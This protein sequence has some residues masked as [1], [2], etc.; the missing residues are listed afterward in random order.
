M[1]FMAA[2]YETASTNL[3]WRGWAQGQPHGNI[4]LRTTARH[5]DPVELAE[6]IAQFAFQIQPRAIVSSKPGV[7]SPPPRTSRFSGWPRK[8]TL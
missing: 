8:V 7:A 2:V 5:A 6:W 4:P 1:S 3:R